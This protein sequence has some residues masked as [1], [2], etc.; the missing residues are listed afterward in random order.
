[1]LPYLDAVFLSQKGYSP[2]TL[3]V[4]YGDVIL[5]TML[6]QAGAQVTMQ[7]VNKLFQYN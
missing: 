3:A 2:L 5:V 7:M 6:L 4:L 1:M